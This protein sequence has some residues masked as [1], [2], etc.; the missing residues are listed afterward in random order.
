ML[1]GPRLNMLMWL[2]VELVEIV[3][4][5]QVLLLDFI[6]LSSYETFCLFD[7]FTSI[8]IGIFVKHSMVFSELTLECLRSLLSGDL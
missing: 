6:R 1:F 3:G 4:E 8:A 7:Y 2:L 5:I